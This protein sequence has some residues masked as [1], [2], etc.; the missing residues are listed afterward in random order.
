MKQLALI[1]LVVTVVV[2][3]LITAL[4]V[5]THTSKRSV[6]ITMLIDGD[7]CVVYPNGIDSDPIDPGFDVQSELWAFKK[8]DATLSLSEKRYA[9]T[10]PSKRGGAAASAEPP[11]NPAVT[12]RSATLDSPMTIT[13]AGRAASRPPLPNTTDMKAIQAHLAE[14]H[15]YL[16]N[17]AYFQPMPAPREHALSYF[18]TEWPDEIAMIR[19]GSP[20]IREYHLKGIFIPLAAFG[21]FLL[22]SVGY[23][24]VTE[25][26][27]NARPKSAATR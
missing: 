16:S 2:G 8:Y 1:S 22:F 6:S 13:P 10:V 14:E 15:A 24:I 21:M 3:G 27:R 18:A 5:R 26:L 12:I 11:K 19:S 4:C 17:P 25:R 9:F 20:P 7:R 23:T